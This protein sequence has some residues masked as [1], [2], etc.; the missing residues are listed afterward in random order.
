MPISAAPRIL[1]VL[2][3][4]ATLGLGAPSPPADAQMKSFSAPDLVRFERVG[5]PRGTDGPGK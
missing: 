4:V 3:A 1:P 5:D 2:L